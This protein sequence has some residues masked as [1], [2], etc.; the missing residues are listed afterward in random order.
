[1]SKRDYYEVLGCAKNC[2]EQEL[3]KAFRKLAMKHHPDRNPDD[4]TAVAK[5]KEAKEAYDVLSDA[6]TRSAY[7]QY[8]HEGLDAQRAGGGFSNA[9]AFSDMFGDMFGDIFGGNNPRNQRS[10][11]YRGAD[12][13]YELELTLEQAAFGDTI[14]ID[15]PTQVPCQRCDGLGSEPGTNPINCK[16]CQGVGQVRVQQGFFSVQQTC[17]SCKGGGKVISSPCGE[18]TGSGRLRK[19]KKLSVKAPAGVDMGDRIRLS[20]EGE[21]GRN[22]GPAGDLYVD[23][24]IIDHPVFMRDKGDL[25]CTVPVSYAT[26]VLGDT[27]QVP[28]LNGN[29]ALKIPSETQSG[30]TFRLRAKGIKLLR[31]SAV[32]DLYCHVQV[33]TPVSLSKEQKDLLKKFDESL[34]INDNEHNPRSS[35]WLVK[36]KNFIDKLS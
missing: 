32:G 30:K 33:E 28:T 5:F 15:I 23:I 29:L 24:L 1:M 13:R 35:S 36:V 16:T 20:G 12:L 19:R 11:V 8:G 31:S 34:N 6:K 26:A 22:G 17:P 27:I 3:K 2:T 4:D 9:D 21:A 10:Q 14:N 7:D 18:C 25:H